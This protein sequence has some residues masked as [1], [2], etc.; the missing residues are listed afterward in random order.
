MSN[1]QPCMVVMG[2]E[3][4]R[5]DTR[6]NVIHGGF[7]SGMGGSPTVI[8]ASSNP[9]PEGPDGRI[10]V[11][12]LYQ[13]AKY[14]N[15]THYF[16]I[17]NQ[18]H[19]VNPYY[20]YYLDSIVNQL[21]TN[22]HFEGSA[23]E[24]MTKFWR[25]NNMYTLTRQLGVQIVKYGTGLG[26]KLITTA[27]KFRKI[28]PLYT[29]SFGVTRDETTWDEE[30]VY[31]GSGG[32]NLKGTWEYGED[33]MNEF[34]RIKLFERPEEVWGYSMFQSCVHA[35][36]CLHA[37]A[38]EDIPAA[39]RNFMTAQRVI[40]ANLDNVD[41]ADRTDKLQELHRSLS[42]FNSARSDVLVI[43]DVHDVGYMGALTGGGMSNRLEDMMGFLE[44]LTS[45]ISLQLREAIS[46]LRQEGANKSIA[47]RQEW[48]AAEM[49]QPLKDQVAHE[50]FAQIIEPHIPYDGDVWLV[51]DLPFEIQDSR[52]EKALKL[53]Q[54]GVIPREY[55][56]V[57]A[58]FNE[59]EFKRR[60][61]V[62]ELTYIE[63]VQKELQQFQQALGGNTEP[64][65]Q[66]GGG[67]TRPGVENEKGEENDSIQGTKTEV[68]G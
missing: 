61:G 20:N 28:Q 30:W 18:M 5:P 7:S 59:I 56:Q 41:E 32:R 9:I 16:G 15:P 65:A 35:L 42:K 67:S 53:F 25:K 23:A 26:R 10:D 4:A 52:E 49:M 43:H 8:D 66:F 21:F 3:P 68:R 19:V 48:K 63:D 14:S 34:V 17:Y 6:F 29:P 50:I 22:Y 54:G 31:A 46:R 40:K 1:A 55:A 62:T 33:Y 36:R 51:H 2:S 38:I 58:N 13:Y 24:E 45:A 27:G 12:A 39:S 47:K 60:Y 37:I 57:L 11:Y 44:P 64:K